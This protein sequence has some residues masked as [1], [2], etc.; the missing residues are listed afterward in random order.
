MKKTL[1]IHPEDRSTD[2]LKPFYGKIENKTI[3]TGGVSKTDI[4]YEIINHDR[5]MMMGHGCSEGLFSVG[6]FGGFQFS[7]I[8]DNDM[9]ELLKTKSDSVFIW[10]N[11][12]HYVRNNNLKGFFSGMFVSEVDE[13]YMFQ[14][15]AEKKLIDESNNRFS[16]ILSNHIDKPSDI[17]Y[18]EVEKEYGELIKRN[19]IAE[20]NHQRL[21]FA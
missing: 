19:P 21:Y 17:I 18:R 10:C 12:D 7:L 13:A 1:I 5:I 11:A 9:S 3:I 8:I 14:L 15:P 6:Q 4:I 16:E 2:F 20:Y